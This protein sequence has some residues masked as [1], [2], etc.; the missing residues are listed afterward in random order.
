MRVE[1]DIFDTLSI[2]PL[3]D[4]AFP[5][6]KIESFVKNVPTRMLMAKVKSGLPMMLSHNLRG[7]NDETQHIRFLVAA[8]NDDSDE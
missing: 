2:D 1:T 7:A 3:F 5:V 4:H 6:E 8:S